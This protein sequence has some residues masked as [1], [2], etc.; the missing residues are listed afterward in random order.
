LAFFFR[1]VFPFAV[2]KWKPLIVSSRSPVA[3]LL[4]RGRFF[5]VH[6]QSERI[7]KSSVKFPRVFLLS[8]L[9]QIH[10]RGSSFL[11]VPQKIKASCL[12]SFPLS[13]CPQLRFAA[14][15]CVRT[16]RACPLHLISLACLSSHCNLIDF[17][18]SCSP[19][20]P[21]FATPQAVTWVFRERGDYTLK[22]IPLCFDL[23]RFPL[24]SRGPTLD[25]SPPFLEEH[26]SRTFFFPP[27][28]LSMIL[29]H[30]RF[31]DWNVQFK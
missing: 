20:L 8:V 12:T 30:I 22:L 24:L 3:V 1:G 2:R 29:F 15:K 17:F 26:L 31:Y 10:L 4:P 19:F 5:F 13:G 25:F 27:F 6:E 28:T 11:S 16:P 9:T 23:S 7:L 14:T 21:A 18:P